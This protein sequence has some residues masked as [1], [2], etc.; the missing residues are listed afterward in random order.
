MLDV[1]ATIDLVY[2]EVGLT[3]RA[4]GI[5]QA[6]LA[7]YRTED[8]IIR[9]VREVLGVDGDSPTDPN[10]LAPYQAEILRTFVREHRIAV[11]GPHGLGKTAIAGWC[12]LWA[13]T[14]FDTDVKVVTTAGAW[15]QLI[16]YTW[17]EVH[18]WSLRADWSKLGLVVR[19][20]RELLATTFRIGAREAFAAAS[21]NPDT[22]EGAHASVVVYIFDEAKMIVTGTW[23]A[24]EGAFSSGE[25]YALA[26]STPGDTSGRFYD[27]HKRKPGLLDWAVRHVT[28]EE[29]IAAHRITQQWADDRKAQWGEDSAVYQNRV[30]GEFADSGENS[31]IPLKWI[32]ASN[33]RWLECNGLGTGEEAWGVDPAYKGEDK[34]A[35]AKL[36]GLVIELLEHR[37]KQDLMR[38]VG[39]M[40][41]SVDRTIPVG[42]DT[43]GVGAGVY[44]RM[45]ELRYNVLS[46][47]VS[48]RTDYKDASGKVGFFNLRAYVWWSIR[49]ALDPALAIGLALPPDD[50]L[51]GDLT[52]PTWWYTSDG[53]IQVESKD[54]LRE[55]I[56][57]SPDLADAVCLAWYTAKHNGV[58]DQDIQNWQNDEYNAETLDGDWLEVMRMSGLDP[59]KRRP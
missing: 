39:W 16:H 55:K 34:T 17:P 19:E 36:V 23:D 53:R 13:V 7:A 42:I 25:C 14:C 8:G 11:R 9:F 35:R 1:D 37:S 15:R 20:G 57:R 26:I 5:D 6:V 51:T 44:S 18:K 56:G 41:S 50:D 2:V 38:T 52:A 27:I 3:E 4:E 22:I 12:V 24:A 28:L 29:G 46:V 21:N 43:I 33:E 47:N 40:T 54:D 30:L 49:E 10:Y 45:E 32:E 58:S 59:D 31:V 48:T